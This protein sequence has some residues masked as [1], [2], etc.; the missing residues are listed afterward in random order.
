VRQHKKA[1]AQLVWGLAYHHIFA[2]MPS[3]MELATLFPWLQIGLAVLLVALILS[4]QSSAGLGSAFGGGGSDG[5][6]YH[7]RRGFE[8]T[9]FQITIVVAILFTMS[10]LGALMFDI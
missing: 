7:T 8:K 2:I 9:L 5:G 3:D 6:G 1:T 10:A 4:Q